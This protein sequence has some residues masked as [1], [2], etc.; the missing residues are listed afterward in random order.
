MTGATGSLAGALSREFLKRGYC[1]HLLART[2]EA[3][4]AEVKKLRSEY[5]DATI[6]KTA[7]DF[8]SDENIEKGITQL[9]KEGPHQYAALVNCAG[10]AETSL[11]HDQAVTH[12]KETFAVNIWAPLRLTH[13]F[14][15]DL[16]HPEAIGVLNIVSSTGRCGNPLLAA[17]GAS[18]GAL[19]TLGESLSREWAGQNLTFTTFVAP[20]MHS[21]MQKR[22]GRVALRYFR[23]DFRKGNQFD[24]KQTKR[25]PP[26]L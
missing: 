19:W 9:I 7:M 14:L 11:F 2:N 1:L 6:T 22:M 25:W 18:N 26:K 16:K 13:A 20:A 24:T 3:L 15:T 17:Y 8:T 21:P 12:L 23:I 4:E 10:F 5:A